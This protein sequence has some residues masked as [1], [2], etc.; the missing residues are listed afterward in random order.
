MTMPVTPAG[1][2]VLGTAEALAGNVVTQL[3]RTGHPFIFGGGLVSI[4][5]KSAVFCYSG[6]E[7]LITQ[8]MMM[9]MA[10]YYNLPSW[11]FAGGSEA[12]LE[13][14]QASAEQA[15]WLLWAA[16]TGCNLCHDVGY[17]ESGVCFSA[18]Q[19][20]LAN[21]FIGYARRVV[22]N[23]PFDPEMLAVDAIHQVGPGGAFINNPHTHRHFRD[24]W[25]PELI[26]R[27]TYSGWEKA[28]STT[29]I[30]RAR[31]KTHHL[32]ETH[33]PEALTPEAEKALD[34]IVARVET[35]ETQL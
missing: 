20:T 27:D 35:S 10:H 7:F 3:V 28:G 11:G 34:E 19:L 22:R 12:K 23:D 17:M 31:A 21:E 1:A 5:M 33:Q 15:M 6:P 2:V 9:S 29:L 24:N 8:A 4:D 16:L 25:F 14:Q 30:E 13:D 18:V 26:D 32:L